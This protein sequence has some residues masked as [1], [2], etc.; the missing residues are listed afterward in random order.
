MDNI[1]ILDCF[2]NMTETYDALF[3]LPLLPPVSE[4]KARYRRG[5]AWSEV[6]FAPRSASGSTIIDTLGV[7]F[8]TVRRQAIADMMRVLKLYAALEKRRIWMPLITSISNH[9]IPWDA[10]SRI[11]STI[12]PIRP[13]KRK[14]VK[15][16]LFS[17]NS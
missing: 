17:T 1:S 6:L 3:N 5:K 13:Y 7:S 9:S 11:R 15:T 4:I 10:C 12:M 16:R 8:Y 2:K 14:T